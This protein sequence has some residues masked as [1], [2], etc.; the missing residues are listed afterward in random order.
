LAETA[1]IELANC[2]FLVPADQDEPVEVEE[3]LKMLKSTAKEMELDPNRTLFAMGS[4]AGDK[5][6]LR[7]EMRIVAAASGRV[8]L[9]EQT[10]CKLNEI[11]GCTIK[12]AAAIAD[13]LLDTIMKKRK[14]F[15]RGLSAKEL[16]LASMGGGARKPLELAEAKLDNVFPSQ[17]ARYAQEP[18]GMITVKN[19]G[20]DDVEDVVVSA[21]LVGF[22][23]QA[24][25]HR[26]GNL[27]AGDT[28]EVPVKILL[29]RKK[30]LG[31]DENRPAML[32]LRLSYR[33]GE[34]RLDQTSSH[35]VMVYDRNSITWAAPQ[36][37]AAFVSAKSETVK[38]FAAL[39]LDDKV[40]DEI[41]HSPLYYPVV[42]HNL[43]KAN[44]IKYLRDAV[45]PYGK[46]ALD[47]VQYAE[48]TLTSGTGDCDDLAVLFSSL[49]ESMG[50]PAALVLTPGHVLM[51]A[52]T[53]V[54]VQHFQ[55]LT[56]DPDKVIF[57]NG[58]VWIPLER[59]LPSATFAEAWARGSKILAEAKQAGGEV[60]VVVVRDAW[61]AYPPVSLA[62]EGKA[63]ELKAPADLQQ[64]TA[65][66]IAGHEKERLAAVDKMI[67]ALE[68]EMKKS[69]RKSP[70]L[71]RLGVVLAREGRRAEA[72]KAFEESRK[73]GGGA[74]AW[75]NLGNVE[76][77]E[78]NLDKG[79]EC[80]NKAL[81]MAPEHV[82]VH[83]NAGIILFMKE[84]FDEAL[85]H[86]VE[87]IE[88]GAQ[89][90]VTLLGQLGIGPGGGAT[91]GAEGG[92]AAGR[93]LAELAVKAFKKAKKEPP[94]EITEPGERKAQEAGGAAMEL[95]NLLFW[96]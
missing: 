44:G 69:G 63:R 92:A 50:S 8:V 89:D 39:A 46:E 86:F 27:S 10:V 14:L 67:A 68:A 80:Y 22:M 75:N 56:P 43:L 54:P 3:N 85:D 16:K 52:G 84:Q 94:K 70:L 48:E 51:A 32:N 37:L 59:T 23:N 55:K 82:K 81:E 58:T 79:L 15:K 38:Q 49:L 19:V 65:A 5:D 29:D 26:H 62:S 71:N 57:V 73:A 93:G 30:L 33:V 53:N 6:D 83:L 96:L 95:H 42:L 72:R 17:L 90:Q 61:K 91:R 36:S 1:G 77:S 87:C 88:L 4:F 66:F 35:S 74:E 24:L 21:Q 60:S 45:N 25:D 40:T 11:S 64:S 9:S 20:E 41:R 7:V 47:Y 2:E 13:N 18:V 12:L 31:L 34:F 76:V 28:T 78:K